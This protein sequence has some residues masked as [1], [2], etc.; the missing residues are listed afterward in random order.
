M[1]GLEPAITEEQLSHQYETVHQGYVDFLNKC[2]SKI[3]K[4][5]YQPEND[6]MKISDYIKADLLIKDIK[7]YGG[8]HANLEFFWE[9]LFSDENNFKSGTYIKWEDS[10]LNKHT[11]LNKDISLYF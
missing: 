5:M 8:A 9:G 4:L 7:N 10:S 6:P 3:E 11:Q 2:F 1:N